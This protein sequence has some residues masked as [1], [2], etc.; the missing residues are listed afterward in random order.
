MDDLTRNRELVGNLQKLLETTTGEG[1]V[2]IETHIS[3]V[4]LAGEYAYKIKKPLD[5]GFLD[6]ST[7]ERRKFCCQEEIRLNRRLAPQIY[8]DVI[9]I[10]GSVAS[11]EIDGGDGA[12]EYAVRMRRFPDEALLSAN[13][14]SLDQ[15][16][17]EAISRVVADFHGSIDIASPESEFGEPEVLLAPMQA[18]FEHIRQLVDEPT[19]L[20]RVEVVEAWTHERFR[21]L[22][23]RLE[24]RKS[25]GFIRECHGD[26]HLGNIAWVDGGVLIFD[27][28]EFNPDLRWIDTMSE[29]AFLLMD[30]DEK[31]RPDLSHRLLNS[32]LQIT[33]DFEGLKVLRFYQVYRAMV[34]AKV[35]AI[36]LGQEGLGE[37]ERSQIMEDFTLYL[38][39]A[40]S[41]TR[42][43]HAGLVITRGLSGSGKSTLAGQIVSGIG[44][45]QLRSD[46]ERKRL[47]G[48]AA[49]ARTD[50]AIAGGI[51]SSEFTQKT[52]A[53][54]LQLSQMAAGSGFVA[55]ADA[56]FLKRDQREPFYGLAAE[57]NVPLVLLDIQVPE[58]ELH[59]RVAM[60][61]AEG[62]DASEADAAVLESQLATYTPL[63]DEEQAWTVVVTPG[64]DSW[65]DQLVA[66][67]G[68]S[69][70][71]VSSWA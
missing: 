22:R 54:M 56:T 27:G 47:A 14:G 66:R 15:Q 8:L 1:V 12:I 23:S 11:P 9:P 38:S 69:S 52:Y 44:A 10:T 13:V 24:M 39:L 63:A 26:L 4:L 53:R 37:S 68:L 17:I 59:R 36:R 31:G 49:E 21:S 35:A 71:S 34:R 61:G 20:A 58:E 64:D 29:L 48:L 30:L 62:A 6:F 16:M 60:R 2:R 25:Q 50:S 46:V 28:I 43:G 55:V 5:L 42:P 32:Y 45:V 40:E 57:M 18:N 67:L 65:R 3:T 7:L 70:S 19:A 51:Y 41:Y 33:G